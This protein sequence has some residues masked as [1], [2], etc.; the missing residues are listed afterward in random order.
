M[1]R[2]MHAGQGGS[3]TDSATL[4]ADSATLSLPP[5]LTSPSSPS[6]AA[7]FAQEGGAVALTETVIG[8]FRIN[9]ATLATEERVG[10]EGVSGRHP[11]GWGGV[12]WGTGGDLRPA[13]RAHPGCLHSQPARQPANP[14][15]PA[16]CPP[17]PCTD[18]GAGAVPGRPE[19]RPHHS[20]PTAHA[21]R[22]PGQH[23]VG[24][25]AGWGGGERW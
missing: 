1:S 4:Y 19:G 6:F 13:L 17:R 3:D 5:S 18:P 23:R 14:A 7:A 20:A 24:G 16:T 10:E 21:R 22:Q 2:G 25:E 8:T 9:P 12:G 15:S 11:V